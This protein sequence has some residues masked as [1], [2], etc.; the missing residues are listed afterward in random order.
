MQISCIEV[1]VHENAN[2]PDGLLVSRMH[3]IRLKTIF[4]KLIVNMFENINLF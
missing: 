1:D 4:V 2:S 3:I